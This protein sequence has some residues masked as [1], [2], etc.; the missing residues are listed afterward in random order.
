M[1][2]LAFLFLAFFV[3]GIAFASQYG[4]VSVTG[5]ATLIVNTSRGRAGVLIC[6]NG[7]TTVFLGL[8]STVTSSTGVPLGGGSCYSGSSPTEVWK[9]PVYGITASGSSDVRYQEYGTG[10]IQ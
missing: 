10:D 7:S 4:A 2:K 5:S 1:R 8:D 3:P 9:G 6:N